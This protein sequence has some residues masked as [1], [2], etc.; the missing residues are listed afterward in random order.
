MILS[1]TAKR[2]AALLFA[3]SAIL[4]SQSLSISKFSLPSAS[5]PQSIVAGPDGA[6]W[7]TEEYSQCNSQGCTFIGKIGRITTAGTITEYAIP[8]PIAEPNGI[9]V[10]PDGA[11]W[12]TEGYAN[13]IGRI[14]AAGTIT[15]FSIPTSNASPSGIAAGPDGALWFIEDEANQ[16][17]RITTAGTVTEFLS[18]TPGFLS[19]IAAGPDGALW[20]TESAGKIGRITTAGT[21][22]EFQVPSGGRPNQIT[23]G[24]DGALWF[25]EFANLVGRIT[26][27]GAVTEFPVPSLGYGPQYIGAGPDGALLF[28]QGNYQSDGIVGRITTS[29]VVTQYPVPTFGS[30]PQGIVQGPDGAI[31][32]VESVAGKIGR[33]QLTTGNVT[34][35]AAPLGRTFQVDGTSY[36]GSVS[37]NWSAGENHTIAA[38]PSPQPGDSGVR[39]IFSGWSDGGAQSHSVVASGS[40]DTYTA[41]FTPQYLLTTSVAPAGG[42]AVT[43]SPS[44]GDGFYAPGTSV[45]VTA[46]AN[47]GYQFENWSSD[48][49]GAANPQSL[50]MDRPHAV[51]ANFLGQSNTTSLSEYP[52]GVSG[53][54][55]AGSDGALWFVEAQKIGRITTTGIV[56]EF[57]GHGSAGGIVAGPDGALWFIED[58]G[59]GRITTAGVS[60]DFSIPN[61]AGPGIT[62]APDGAL[63]FTEQGANKIGRITTSG[64]VSEFAI[65]TAGSQASAI[66]LGPDGAIWFTETSGNKIGRITTAGAITEYPI[67]TP[68]AFTRGI[69]SG[70]D[71]ALWFTETFVSKIGRLTTSGVFTEFNIPPSAGGSFVPAVGIVA[72][73]DSALWFSAT[74]QVGRVTTAG[75]IS[76]YPVASTAAG[77]ITAGPDGALWFTEPGDRKIGRLTLPTAT[78]CTYSLPQGGQSFFAGP[79]NATAN[80]RTAATCT[81]S[82]SN[83]VPWITITD[84]GSGRGN[85]TVVYTVTPNPTASPRSGTLTIAGLPYTVMQAAVSSTLNCRAGVSSVPQVALEGR[86]E[87]LGDYLVT[88]TGLSGALTGDVTF[89]LNTNVTNSI[90]G[91]VTDALLSV[92][93]GSVR[94]GIVAGY[95]SLRWP[96]VSLTSVGGTASIRITGVRADA[97]LSLTRATAANPG[98]SQPA[99]ILGQVTISGVPVAG[100]TQDLANATQTLVFT[101][102]SAVTV[103]AQA[104]VPMVFQEA[105]ANS[106]QA[107][108]TRLRLKL[109]HLPGSAQVYA[110]VFPMEGAKAQLLSADANGSGGSP[111]AGAPFQ[112]GTYQQLTPSNGVFTATWLVQSADPGIIDT[113]TFPF[114]L[115]NAGSADV[116][117][118]QVSGSL[119]PV[120]TVSIASTSAP[121]PRYRDFSAPQ[122]LTN[123]RVSTSVQIG[124]GGRAS[125]TSPS[126]QAALQPLALSVGSNVTFTTSIV[127]DTSDPGQSATGVI[128][129]NN[130]PTGLSLIS[131]TT[132]MGVCSGSGGQVQIDSLAP[133]QGGLI[134]VVAQV[135]PAFSGT[136]LDIPSSAEANEVTLDLNASTSDASIIV[137]PQAI[138][139][140]P[141]PPSPSSGSANSQTFTFQFSNP[142]GYQNLGVVNVLINNALDGR[143]ACYLAYSVPSATLYLVNDAGDAG[144]P[145]AGIVPLGSPNTIQN[146]QCGVALASVMGSGATLTLVLSISFKSAFGGNKVVYVA[147]RDQAS[148]NSDWQ[149]LGVW[150]VPWTSGVITATNVTP[151]RGTGSAGTSQQIKFTWTDTRGTGDIG[152]VN[153]LIN[154]FIDGRNSCYL[155]YSPSSNT[156]Y[157][158]DD[159][160]DAGGPFAGSMV[161]NGGNLG[162]ENRQCSI[163]GSGSFVGYAP[164]QMTLTLNIAFKSG[165]TGNRVVYIAGRDKADGNNTGWQA[166]GTWTVQ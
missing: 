33:A 82:V 152:I 135:D 72:G 141:L 30:V 156:M 66:V 39:Y 55:T 81:W 114:V 134:S 19:D 116:A 6:L 44:S 26:T 128:V 16:I 154:N 14:T 83:S 20:F 149:P 79:A 107:G 63:W 88:C 8:T 32:F 90:T 24:P 158:V 61:G 112:G 77:A 74:G 159:A 60:S 27:N 111:V 113:F 70:P 37:F 78:A 69:A 40:I 115:V 157:L 130:L 125:G 95:N 4:E 97:S 129:R 62:T 13:K 92:N 91:G 75:E 58:G 43:A 123:L 86:T 151:P 103:G 136:V 64:A 48:L 34:V 117:A 51:Q 138:S 35:T 41:S 85:G 127:N 38:T 137:Q 94:K 131:C 54:I 150:Q 118:S 120:S 50:T 53:G 17:G 165:F 153:V 10:G 108:V 139:L 46:A 42:G 100:A 166:A 121:V 73:P 11:L 23:K 164:N 105:Q 31:W 80:V 7:F 45:K 22:S 49:F 9:T 25:T 96:G 59:I 142:A 56:T 93:G 98:S 67:P 160:G 12:F 148:G 162:I 57:P 126:P 36:T 65:P 104:T 21:I 147:A 144:G 47:T 101:E 155:A 2:C 84:P 89:T 122:K 15:E 145:Y 76:L 133:N 109:A 3:T 140:G 18:P 87:G 5:Q 132:T 28:T 110:P 124:N 52:G 1:K 163:N 161:L 102:Q 119:A 143:S 71:G 68:N 99:A 29:G 106:F 146:S